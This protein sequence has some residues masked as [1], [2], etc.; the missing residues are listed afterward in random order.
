M[1]TKNL[2]EL[3]QQVINTEIQ[4]ITGLISRVDSTY[5]DACQLLLGC[6]GRV[7]LIGMGKSGHIARKIAATLS[8]TGTPSYFVHPAE[9]SH[10]DLGMLAA[11]D[12]VMMISNSGETQEILTLLPII[13]LLN[14]STIALTGNPH[15]TLAKYSTVHLN[16]AVEKEACPLGLAPT[17]STT[18]ALV[19]GDAIAITLLQARG[20]NTEDFARVHPGGT[21]G[22]RL[23]FDT[24]EHLMAAG[25]DLPL[26][27]QDCF[28][29]EALSMITQKKLGMTTIA[30]DHG[31]LCGIF[32]DGDLRR[33][34]HHTL[35]IHTTRMHAIMTKKCLTITKNSLAAE[36]LQ[37]ME[38]HKITTLVVTE[39][40]K[41]IGVIHMHHL[42][43]AGIG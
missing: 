5:A 41:P 7:I 32:T 22:R 12:V 1:N 13:K 19:M 23:I 15:S 37:M 36:A 25:D 11:G 2:C 21:L 27:Q 4:A 34:L 29:S 39:N 26:V 42:L 9:A 6:K 38:K 43:R 10:G 14:L 24:V 28:L 17:S 30:D 3:G 40:E 20:F 31:K 16:I 35:D 18:A 33:A 8:S